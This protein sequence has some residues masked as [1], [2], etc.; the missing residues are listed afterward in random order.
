MYI[1]TQIMQ[2]IF[3]LKRMLI[4]AVK[5]NPSEGLLF[6]GGLDSAILAAIASQTKAITVSL[7]SYGRDIEYANLCTKKFNLK[8]YHKRI[9]T[10]EA[11]DAIPE[12]IKILKSFD[13][14]IPNDMVVYFGLKFAK[15]MGIKKVMAGDGSDELFAGYSF[16]KDIN[17]LSNYIEHISHSMQF[18]SNKIGGYFGIEIIQPY[19]DKEF[20]EFSLSIPPGLK[21]KREKGRIWGK[22]ILRKA[23]EDVLPKE[24][25]W[26]D[27]RPLE[28]GSG[29]TKLR[30]IISLRISDEEF[31]EKK[32]SYPIKF[33]NKEHLYYYEVYRNIVGEIPKPKLGQKACPACGAGMDTNAFH[34]KVCGSVQKWEDK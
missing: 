27:K 6:S 32:R 1:L 24:I 22:W 34:C 31:G 4:G 25:I 30:E 3:E 21:I 23:F 2:I 15:E 28:Y 7:E 5:G 11:I 12:V 13:L 8:H 33:I 18:N 20:I 19:L 16:M 26:Q 9:N 14:A 10:N 29:M 17:N